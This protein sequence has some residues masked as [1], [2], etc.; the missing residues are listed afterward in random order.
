MP[1]II[2]PIQATVD[3]DATLDKIA[4]VVDQI[5]LYS[6]I[7][8]TRASPNTV[9]ENN[10]LKKMVAQMTH[11]VKAMNKRLNAL[12]IYHP[13][14]QSSNKNRYHTNFWENDRKC[15]QQCDFKVR[16]H[17]NWY[18]GRK[19]RQILSAHTQSTKVDH[20]TYKIPLPPSII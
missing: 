4:G 15:I 19:R 7:H 9:K 13:C 6:S 8:T 14:G 16:A 2:Q 20:F 5:M 18:T 11:Q 1:Q 10:E 17:F 3:K 12:T